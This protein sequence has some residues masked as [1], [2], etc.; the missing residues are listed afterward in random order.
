MFVSLRFSSFLFV[1]VRLC[2]FLQLYIV[3]SGTVVADEQD[4]QSWS[5]GEAFGVRGKALALTVQHTAI[6]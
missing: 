1:S 5:V 3:T 4:P 2:L 6:Y